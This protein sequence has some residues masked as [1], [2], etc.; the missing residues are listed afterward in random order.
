MDRPWRPARRGS[1]TRKRE[2]VFTMSPEIPRTSA[3][4]GSACPGH[5]A[6]YPRG[7]PLVGFALLGDGMKRLSL[8]GF[9]GLLATMIAG[10]PI[11][12]DQNGTSS[13][14]RG[15]CTTTGTP[16]GSCNGPSDCALNETCGNDNQCH[17]G[18]CTEWGC[19]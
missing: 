18:D 6:C 5:V 10:C 17:P 1:A 12:N 3:L 14:E 2:P 9:V 8:L 19:N 13:C 15:D 16:P 4:L 11:Y 7:W